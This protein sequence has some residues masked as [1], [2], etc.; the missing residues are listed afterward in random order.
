MPQQLLLLELPADLIR[1]FL[2]SFVAR[3]PL[4][5][6]TARFVCR[7][8]LNLLPLSRETRQQARDFCALAAAHGYL[9][10]INWARANGCPWNE[11]TCEQ[12]AEGGHLEVLQW[13]RTNG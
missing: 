5:H 1:L 11:R 7:R 12:A 10:L 2:S 8:F 3:S 9:N 13:A 4:C 6:I